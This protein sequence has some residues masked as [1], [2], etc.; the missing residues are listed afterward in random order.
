MRLQ[1]APLKQEQKK[2]WRPGTHMVC[3]F[4]P[5]WSKVAGACAW[6]NTRSSD[7]SLPACSGS[8]W[9]SWSSLALCLSKWFELVYLSP[10]FLECAAV[11]PE[12]KHGCLSHLVWTQ[13]CH[14]FVMQDYTVV[15]WIIHDVYIMSSQKINFISQWLYNKWIFVSFSS[16]KPILTQHFE[17]SWLTGSNTKKKHCLFD[18]PCATITLC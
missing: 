7:A 11:K 5:R 4:F 3:T 14:C 13:M 12:H 8:L 2:K 9:A 18:C 1:S 15:W 17:Y 10:V 16:L 6:K